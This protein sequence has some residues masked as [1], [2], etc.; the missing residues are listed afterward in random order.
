MYLRWVLIILPIIGTLAIGPPKKRSKA[1]AVDST[2]TS[3]STTSARV[4]VTSPMHRSIEDWLALNRESLILNSNAVNLPISGSTS[5]LA[6]AL[7]QHYL[8]RQHRYNYHH[9]PH[10]DYKSSFVAYRYSSAYCVF[11]SIAFKRLGGH[12]P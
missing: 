4:S 5:D 7:F 3:S 12:H 6:D 1:A 10:S 9:C 2:T 11:S 8:P